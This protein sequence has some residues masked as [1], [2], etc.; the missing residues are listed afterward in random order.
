MQLLGKR[1]EGS[2]GGF[3]SGGSGGQG[4]RVSQGASGRGSGESR[5]STTGSGGSEGGVV[6]Q[7]NMFVRTKSDSGKRLT[8]QEILQQIKVKNLDTGQNQC[9]L[10]AMQCKTE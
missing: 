10:L 3:S 8:D 9:L 7:L 5:K 6:K 4:S 1:K 2:S